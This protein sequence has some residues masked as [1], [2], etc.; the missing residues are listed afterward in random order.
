MCGRTTLRRNDH[1]AVAVLLVDQWLRA[2]LA[3]LS[4][5]RRQEKD[6][7]TSLPP[8]ADFA[9]GLAVALHVLFAEQVLPSAHS[10]APSTSP[11]RYSAALQL[12]ADHVNLGLIDVL[13][14]VR[15]QR[16]APERGARLRKGAAFARVDQEYSVAIPSHEIAAG[17]DVEDARPAMRMHLGGFSG[18]DPR[19]QDTY[20]FVL[21]EDS[22]RLGGRRQGIE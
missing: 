7:R 10:S 16:A 3:A 5:L 6:L 14:S 2:R 9:A 18:C 17:E 19:F 12:D 13:E 21:E 15:R 11:R 20:V 22:M 1:V 4:A 8:V